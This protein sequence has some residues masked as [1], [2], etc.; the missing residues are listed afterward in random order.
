M[1]SILDR[2]SS[3][4]SSD[5]HKAADLAHSTFQGGLH[6]HGHHGR[7]LIETLVTLCRNHPNL[8]GIGVGLAVEQLLSEEK[9]E[10]ERRQLH[11]A[12]PPAAPEPAPSAFPPGFPVDPTASPPPP[13]PVPA[14]VDHGMQLP[15][16][17]RPNLEPARLKL[18]SI[19][20]MRLALEV[21]GGLILIKVG[22]ALAHMFR[23]KQPQHDSWFASAARIHTLSAA[24]AAYCIA[25]SLRAK[26]VSAWR[27]AAI[28]LFATDAIKPLLNPPKRLRKAA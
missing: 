19:K 9:R 2:I 21:F 26:R 20:P 1:A 22:H 24:I 4:V 16:L 11:V 5:V 7:A 27:N 25:S 23:R 10:F 18:H 3:L 15:H 13:A 17:H 12:P 28:G 8:V 14:P 6:E